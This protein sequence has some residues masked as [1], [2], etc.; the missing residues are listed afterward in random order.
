MQAEQAYLF[1]HAMLREVAYEL[2]LPSDRSRLHTL[3]LDVLEQVFAADLGRVA[4]ELAEHCH[5]AQQDMDPAQDPQALED[6]RRREVSHLRLARQLAHSRVQDDLAQLYT[7]RLLASP[8]IERAE[9]FEFELFLIEQHQS[10]GRFSEALAGC[11]RVRAAPDCPPHSR[12]RTWVAEGR[13]AAFSGRRDD[14]E[15]LM[16]TAASEA[17]AFGLPDLEAQATSWLAGFYEDSGQA[18]LCEPMHRKAAEI[19]Q[20]PGMR[21][22]ALGNLA[23]H[24][25]STGRLDVAVAV[26]EE[27]L[28]GFERLG[29]VRGMGV[30]CN[31]LGRTYF[32]LGR[33]E[34]SEAAYARSLELMRPAGHNLSFAF[35]QGNIAEVWQAQGQLERAR[36][37]LTLAI[38]VCDEYAYTMH[39]AA[40]RA[41]LADLLLLRGESEAAAETMDDARSHFTLAGAEQYIA[42][43]CDIVRVRLAAEQACKSWP[44]GPPASAWLPVIRQLIQ[45]MV[46]A[47]SA[48]TAGDL[49][50]QRS[51]E[52]GQA[53]LHELEAAAA[54]RRPA[55][56]WRGHLPSQLSPQLRKT[57]LEQGRGQAQTA[58]L[59]AAH[60]ALDAAMK[61]DI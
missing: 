53:V 36:K 24:L 59:L 15:R 39:G 6:L 9:A 2:W 61:A 23:N 18:H 40:F 56:L 27:V 29:D 1:R 20:S 35:S 3:A 51:L 38:G 42:S 14:A 55:V 11:A 21:L 41:R 22:A 26:L 30:A 34:E 45:G 54:G 4:G 10:R 44:P 37:A 13:I 50:L 43:Y 46:H 12:V 52:A 32:M 58:R 57:L 60:P 28:A 31:N 16:E 47:L 49:E 48:R 5:R 33:L 17:R 7:E 25:R 19:A 8:L